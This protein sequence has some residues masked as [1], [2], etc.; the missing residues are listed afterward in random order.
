MRGGFPHASHAIMLTL[1][2]LLTPSRLLVTF[3]ACSL[4]LLVPTYLSVAQ[5]PLE[6]SGSNSVW[7]QQGVQKGGAVGVRDAL[8]RAAIKDPLAQEA[9]EKLPNYWKGPIIMPKLENAT[10][11]A[12]LG[13]ASWK[14]LHTMAARFPVEPTEDE[15]ETFKSFLYLFSR[16]YPCGECAAEFQALLLKHPPQTSSR[17]AASIH[18]CH[19]HNLVNARLGKDEFDCGK[20]LEI[21]YD[22]GCA[23]DEPSK[24]STSD[25]DQ[26]PTLLE[27]NKASD[28]TVDKDGKRKD[29]ITGKDLVGG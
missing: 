18:L 25:D 23:D 4:L 19:L 27:R 1:R 20:G 12:E 7:A 13:R 3:L 21:I 10:V 26:D 17:S 29:A 11:K 15:K 8:A 14:L 2:Q 22:C 9:L 5:S 6:R 24:T 28:S 16:L